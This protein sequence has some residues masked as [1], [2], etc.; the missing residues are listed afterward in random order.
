M[1][2][3]IYNSRSDKQERVW[4]TGAPASSVTAEGNIKVSFQTL[5]GQNVL[6][7]LWLW[8]KSIKYVNWLFWDF[9]LRSTFSSFRWDICTDLLL[10]KV[11]GMIY[12]RDAVLIPGGYN[13]SFQ[14]WRQRRVRCTTMALK[15]IWLQS[16]HC[17]GIQYCILQRVNT[18]SQG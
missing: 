4:V 5:W 10:S 9:F 12:V 3:F 11:M 2:A 1:K 14:Q 6:Q 16:L 7:C 13:S 17:F 18:G 15:L 8:V